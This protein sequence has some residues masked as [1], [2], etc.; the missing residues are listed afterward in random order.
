M[1]FAQFWRADSYGFR[2]GV[3]AHSRTEDKGLAL[4]ADQEVGEYGDMA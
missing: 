4:R 2:L 3:V 1:I